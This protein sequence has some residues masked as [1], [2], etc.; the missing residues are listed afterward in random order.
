MK[1][2]FFFLDFTTYTTPITATA[3]MPIKI[4]VK[5]EPSAFAVSSFGSLVSSVLSSVLS[6]TLSA[7]CVFSPVVSA[8]LFDN[9]LSLVGIADSN[10]AEFFGSVSLLSVVVFSR[11]FSLTS[12]RKYTFS[13]SPSR[14]IT[15]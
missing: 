12:V 7:P 9:A 15:R 13:S 6:S 11:S 1:F 3:A 4:Y 10:A 2:S 14:S 5:P 8:L